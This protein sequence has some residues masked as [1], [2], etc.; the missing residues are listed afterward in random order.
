MVQIELDRQTQTWR[1]WAFT[2][3]NTVDLGI[4]RQK[5]PMQVNGGASEQ[6]YERLLNRWSDLRIAVQWRTDQR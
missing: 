1:I 5:I 6:I 2:D 4:H 3:R